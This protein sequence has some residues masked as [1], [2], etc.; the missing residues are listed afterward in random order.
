MKFPEGI[1]VFKPLDT[2]PEFVK[3]V[4]LINGEF[5]E[6]FQN[7]HNKGEVKIEILESKKGNYYLSKNEYK[8]S[9][10]TV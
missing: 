3:G 6:W 10:S 9:D 7:N 1:R 4:L 2:Q 5:L 8:P